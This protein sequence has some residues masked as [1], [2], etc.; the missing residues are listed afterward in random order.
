M[1][2]LARRA[3]QTNFSASM[4]VAMRARQL[5][6]EGR[7]VIS[8]AI[9]DPD[10][11]APRHAV[12]AAKAAAD[13]GRT[14]YPP[15]DGLPELKDA[16]RRKFARDQ[17]VDYA[18]NEVMVANG[19]KQAITNAMLA[20]LDPGDEVVIPVPAWVAYADVVRL[21]DGV[22]R[23]VA[24]PENNG[25]L[26]RVEDIE[27]AIG[28]RTR[29][30]L[31]NFP[32]NPTGAVAPPALLADI[33]AMLARHPQLWVMTDDMYEH[34]CFA[35]GGHRSI[36][37]VAPQLR[38]RTLVVS[39]VSKTY[40]MTGWRVGFAG[41]PAALIRAM[42]VMQGHQSAGVNVVAQAAAAAALDG[43]QEI[44]AE[45][46]AIYRERRDIAV[47]GLNAAGL[48]CHTPDGA[49]YAFPSVAA[50]LGRTT[51][52][53]R[54]IATDADFAM[55]LLE[56]AGVATVPGGAFGMSPFIRISTATDTDSLREAC[57][58][59]GAFCAVL[60]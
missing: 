3:R 49:F 16:V 4:S 41:G 35:P 57:R 7:D 17:G 2:E 28:P 50:M 42:S 9:G 34:L 52:G 45:R 54:P 38:D 12:E 31:L 46:A 6:A 47:A 15:L 43:P 40:A 60:A 22:P 48:R 36:V 20:T 18:P 55:A 11:P 30:L 8:L 26:P 37:S 58:R 32:N 59:I 53:G 13:R 14:S 23:F 24:C 33:A 44:V 56:E 21:L 1:P 27:A 19:G 10:L 51:P 25:F 29:W 39:G 5:R